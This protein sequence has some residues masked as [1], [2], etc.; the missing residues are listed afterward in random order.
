MITTKR[1]IYTDIAYQIK[2]IMVLSLIIL[3]SIAF[4][5]LTVRMPKFFSTKNWIQRT[6]QEQYEENIFSLKFCFETDETKSHAE[7]TFLRINQI[8]KRRLA[9]RALCEMCMDTRNITKR[10]WFIFS[11]RKTRSKN[12]ETY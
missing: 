11:K 9:I 7:A 2:M 1:N 3:C 4:N 6:K 8:I 10:C 5:V 12:Y